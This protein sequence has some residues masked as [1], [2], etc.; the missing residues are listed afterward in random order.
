MSQGIT[1][2]PDIDG[3][4]AIAVLAVLI[5]H[6]QSSWLPGGFIGV[7]IFFV[8]SGFVVSAS[9]TKLD[10]RNFWSFS[11]QFYARRLARIVPALVIVLCVSSLAAT[12]FIPRAWLSE[13]S[14]ETALYAFWG[15]SNWRLQTN[16]DVYFAPRAELN[17]FTQTWSLGVEEQFYLIAPILF[18]LW[19]RGQ[20]PQNPRMQQGA[21]LIFTI[22]GVVSLLA[23][24]WFTASQPTIAFY[25]IVTR[26]WELALGALL[27]LGS[28]HQFSKLNQSVRTEVIG[29]I[30]PWLGLFLIGLA[31]LAS[32][33]V[34]FPWPWALVAC[35]GTLC[36]LG[37]IQV[38][39]MHPLR[40]AL[41]LPPWV[42]IGKRSY[43]LYLWH[44]PVFVLM[45][46][47]IGLES[48][49]QLGFALGLTLLLAMTTYRF[50]E[51]PIRH[52]RLVQNR[53]RAAV[54]SGLLVMVFIGFISTLALFANHA[55]VSLSQVSRHANDWHPGSLRS[56][57]T[58]Q[59]SCTMTQVIEP[60][61]GGTQRIIQAKECQSTPTTQT[62]YLLGD[63][64][65]GAL[66]PLFEELGAQFG[67]T[68]RVFSFQG[69]IATP[70]A[71][72]YLDLQAP[73]HF[74]RAPGCLTFNEAVRDYVS[75]HARSNDLIVLASLRMPR[76]GDQWAS[77]GI[78]DMAAT[79]NT[80][81]AQDLRLQAAAE[82]NVWLK[83][84]LQSGAHTIFIAPSPVFRAPVFRCA[85]WF[86][87]NNPICVGQNRQTRADLETLRKPILQAMEVPAQQIPGV[88]IWDPLPSLCNEKNCEALLNGRP[89]FFDGDH[90]SNYGNLILYPNFLEWLRR[91][92]L[93]QPN[94]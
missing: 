21:L 55:S 45:R 69:K 57:A 46:W 53:S 93:L 27:C 71:C 51:Q 91:N 18:Y 33:P 28:T 42:W 85:D 8:I 62:I 12:L 32:Q 35:V 80:P 25:S 39:T 30:L 86:N 81:I 36:I 49:L 67:F 78:H 63:S 60:F 83:P 6:L 84:L 73:M 82:I 72:S 24:A 94:S 14:N 89:L 90:L 77:F 7:D 54:I 31:C 22:F 74:G 44:W 11:A 38:N 10:T 20:N 64:H 68:I 4:R 37:G 70:Y 92:R 79:I 26:F 23:C 50:V 5:Y 58:N 16:T 47:T 13:L 76:Y 41:A 34:L 61:H 87:A 56:L 3:L 59:P 2:R 88:L 40:K 17:P 66:I 19:V 43:S 52:H 75:T 15:L 9:I 1:Y 65:A 29:K 48:P